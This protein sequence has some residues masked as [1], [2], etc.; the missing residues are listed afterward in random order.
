[1]RSVVKLLGWWQE[2][3]RLYAAAEAAVGHKLPGL[4]T[5]EDLVSIIRVLSLTR[6]TLR[7][8]TVGPPRQSRY[9][10]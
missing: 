10:N 5:R 8:M 2:R 4:L 3:R 7:T 1:M 9:V 6:K